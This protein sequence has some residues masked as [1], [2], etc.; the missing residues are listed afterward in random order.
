MQ[1][2][3]NAGMMIEENLSSQH[4]FLSSFIF[5]TQTKN[6]IVEKVKKKHEFLSTS[7][8]RQSL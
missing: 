5:F 7:S 3:M 6:L 4:K 1:N 2:M 8:K